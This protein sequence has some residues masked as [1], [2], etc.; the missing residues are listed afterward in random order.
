MS[1]ID[2]IK[3][4][5]DGMIEENTWMDDETRSAALNKSSRMLRHIGFAD[6]ILNDTKLD[7][8]YDGVRAYSILN[9]RDSCYSSWTSLLMILCCQS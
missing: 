2:E 4:A 1:M 5:F 7:E 8:W 9:S 3:T 6:W